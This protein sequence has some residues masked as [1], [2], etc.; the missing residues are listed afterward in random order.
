MGP[1]S[2]NRI[3]R[4][5]ACCGGRYVARATIGDDQREQFWQRI[6]LDGRLGGRTIGGLVGWGS[7]S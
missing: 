3:P 1:G 4:R 5:G 2:L 7:M 6:I